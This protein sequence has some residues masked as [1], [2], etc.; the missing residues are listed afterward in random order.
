MEA[1][2][3]EW[4]ETVAPAIQQLIGGKQGK[5]ATLA[6]T[7]AAVGAGGTAAEEK[8]GGEGNGSVASFLAQVR[9]KEPT[10]SCLTGQSSRAL[11]SSSAASVAV[12]SWCCVP[13]ISSCPLVCI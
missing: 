5:T 11:F 3:D 10:S 12:W 1:M 9:K 13:R 7:A 6:V 8:E 4:E 2:H